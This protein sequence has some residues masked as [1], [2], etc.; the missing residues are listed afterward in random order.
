MKRWFTT[1]MALAVVALVGA[2]GASAQTLVKGSGNSAYNGAPNYPLIDGWNSIESDTTLWGQ[3]GFWDPGAD[4]LNQ[5]PPCW[6]GNK[7][8]RDYLEIYDY[9]AE[10]YAGSFGAAPEGESAVVLDWGFFTDQDWGGSSAL[11]HILPDSVAFPNRADGDLTGGKFYDFSDF[12]HISLDYLVIQPESQARATDFRIKTQEASEGEPTNTTQEDWYMNDPDMYLNTDGAWV[13]GTYPLESLGNVSPSTAGFSRPGCPGSCWSGI[14]GNGEFDTDKLVGFQ[15]EWTSGNLNDDST[16]AGTIVWDNFRVS[17][18]RYPMVESME[19]STDGD[20]VNGTGN[21]TVS[22][23]DDAIEGLQSVQID[24]TVVGSES[25]GGSVDLDFTPDAGFYDVDVARTSLSLFYKVLTPASLPNANLTVKIMEQS[26][27]TTEEW[28]YQFW[29]ALNDDTGNWHRL[30]VPF[31]DMYHPSWLPGSD[32]VIDESKIVESQI[33]LFVG[34]GEES[35]GSVLFDRYGGYG[36]QETDYEAPVAPTGISASSGV[37][38]NVVSWTDVP[39]EDGETY[40]I[41]VSTLPI[42]GMDDRRLEFVANVEEGVEI[43]TH[44]LF[45]PAVDSDLEYYYAVLATDAVGNVGELG[46]ASTS[47]TTTAKA[48]PTIMLGTPAGWAADGDLGEWTGV[49]PLHVEVGT[50]FGHVGNSGGV[51][52]SDAADLSADYYVAIDA[53]YLYYGIDVNDEFYKPAPD[54]GSDKWLFDGVEPYIGLYDGRGGQHSGLLGGAEP[55]FHINLY[56]N[57]ATGVTDWEA[58]NG[59]GEYYVGARTGG[60]VAELRVP[61]TAMQQDGFEK[62]VA[63]DGM[64]LPIDFSLF[65]DDTPGETGLRETVFPYSPYNMDNSWQS[66]ENWFY[67]WVGTKYTAVGVESVSSDVPKTF[68]LYSNYPNPFNPSTVF[69]Y[70]L[71]ETGR[72]TLKVFNVLGQEVRTLVD[73]DQAAGT[74]EVR[75]DARDLASGV[76]LYQLQ[77]GSH[78]QARKMLLVR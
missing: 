29:G 60:W 10:G 32:G 46:M 77:S 71:P 48:L 7:D 76:Y 58:Y 5:G 31:A 33:Q 70:D 8:G 22:A 73:T 54:A 25:W 14:Y 68:N 66:P 52:P 53:D 59:D 21:Y 56:G 13:T 2:A 27:G 65:D 17:G 41:Y 78:I 4:C 63:M 24:Y 47:V 64:R 75:F 51:E 9:T 67:T 69:R 39:E 23:S 19:G 62:F 45:Y 43:Y 20:W 55:D 35:T 15:L 57:Q 1:L 74:Y 34:P 11:Q 30:V 40:S 50:D 36:F 18:E 49:T 16:R 37:Y 61:L 42:T 3:Y 12:T 38:A 26:D 6:D 72:V 44:K 28:H